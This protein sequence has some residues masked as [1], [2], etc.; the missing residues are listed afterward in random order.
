MG[1]EALLPSEVGQNA[2]RPNTAHGNTT[3]Y[4]RGARASPSRGEFS[5]QGRVLQRTWS[6]FL[7]SGGSPTCM[8]GSGSHSS[9]APPSRSPPDLAIAPAPQRTAASPKTSIK[10]G[11]G[12]GPILL[13][14]AI[15]RVQVALDL[16]RGSRSSWRFPSAAQTH[17]SD[18]RRWL[19]AAR[20]DR[21]GGRR[22]TCG[23]AL[24]LRASGRPG[25]EE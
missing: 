20:G 5:E 10:P 17:A 7:V 21:K 14:A 22:C 12:C 9:K 3:D 1:R 23:G 25:T 24:V 2:C 6:G 19:R 8:K 16:L 11:C 18:A 15:Y 4:P 13:D